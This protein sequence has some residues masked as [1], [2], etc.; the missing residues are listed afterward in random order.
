LLTHLFRFIEG[1]VVEICL[2]KWWSS[3][4]NTSLTYTVTFMGAQPDPRVIVMHASESI[5]RI[6]VTSRFSFEVMRMKHS[7][8]SEHVFFKYDK[9]SR[10][11]QKSSLKIA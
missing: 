9:F 2:A 10:F 8:T 5:K 3:L 4:G 1:G 11:I 7:F 6:D